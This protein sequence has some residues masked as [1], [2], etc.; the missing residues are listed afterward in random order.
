M[1]VGRRQQPLIKQKSAPSFPYN[2][3]QSHKVFTRKKTKNIRRGRLLQSQTTSGFDVEKKE[4]L[5]FLLW[6]AQF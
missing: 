5:T 2:C 4:P 1:V 3:D 6:G